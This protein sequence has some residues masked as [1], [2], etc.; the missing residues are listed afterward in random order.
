MKKVISIFSISFSIFIFSQEKKRDS[1]DNILEKKIQEVEL[2]AKKKLVERKI[3]RV[4]FNVENSIS[5][6]GGNAFEVLK[7]TPSIRIES[8]SI[9]LAGKNSVKVMINDRL[10]QLSGE[11]LINYLKNIPSETIK[12]IEVITN[13]PA[14][15]DAEG[16]SGL[17]NI[18][19][20][21]SK[22]NA[23]NVGLRSTYQQANYTT[24]THGIGFSYQKNKLSVLADLSFKYG[25]ELY[26]NDI[27]Y[28][29]PLEHW[30]NY[31]FNRKHVNNIGSSINFQYELSKKSI[32]GFQYSGTFSDNSTDEF[33]LNKSY[34]ASNSPLKNYE[35]NGTSFT[36][37]Q[38]LSFNTNYTY[39]IDTLG[40]TFSIDLDYFNNQ[41]SKNN[42]FN[43]VMDNLYD[44]SVENVYAMNK[45]QQNI[46]NYSLKTDFDLPYRFAHISFG[47][48]VV[49]TN[50]K[51]NVNANLYNTIDYSPI[52]SQNDN[53]EY[54]ENIQSLYF[55]TNRTFNKKWEVKIGLRGEYTQTT[56]NSI[57]H[58][59]I[60]KNEYF[61]LFPTM[62]LSY[63]ANENNMISASFG[64]R[65]RRP[66][67]WELNPAR[68]YQNPSS[69]AEGNPFL[70]PSFI[71]NIE[72][73]YAYK[74]LF[75]L[76]LYYSNATDNFGQL[77]FHNTQNEQQ[78]FK[79][80][81]FANEKFIGGTLTVNH[82]PLTWWDF[83]TEI[84]SGYC[85]SNPYLDILATHYSGWYGYT[86]MANNFSLNEAKTFL[87][88][89]Y[90]EYSFPSTGLNSFTAHSSLNMGLKY[91]L[92]DK[93]ITLALHFNDILKNDYGTSANETSGIRQNFT[94]Y[95]DTRFIRLAFNYNFGNRNININKRTTG[96]QEEKNRN[97]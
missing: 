94:Q 54:T 41:S 86:N 16:S 73:N 38:N 58:N 31:I 3:D 77:T 48:K 14:K 17:I 9:V 97:N 92:L 90:Y 21:T 67:F 60:N 19:L 1:L 50:T 18:Q 62:Y 43:S 2:K 49:S 6:V 65:V 4:I 11:D 76:N 66:S 96:N 85:E 79:R 42:Q 57:S 74:N 71:Y 44:N 68:W 13:P 78:T 32:L 72:V 7:I 23:W 89:L 53:F 35:T 95:Y 34:N 45:A 22:H 51:N 61:K 33:N 83:S 91:L 36:R 93:K 8:E 28:Y 47:A 55:S 56:S 27:N 20:K 52:N 25:K 29:Y 70:Q 40:K 46:K 75:N 5:A 63:K 64:R 80:L 15:Y 39:K 24:L 88:T 10:T 12:K 30:K 69:Y 87:A 82:K 26:T 37:P 81:N 59:Q 84:G